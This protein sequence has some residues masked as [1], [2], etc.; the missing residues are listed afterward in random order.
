MWD[1]P[2]FSEIV[3]KRHYIEIAGRSVPID[4]IRFV[5]N[6]GAPGAKPILDIVFA[7]DEDEINS[8]PI[9]DA[10]FY[11]A[12]VRSLEQMRDAPYAGYAG[13]IGF[14]DATNSIRRNDPPNAPVALALP[15]EGF[16]RVVDRALLTPEK[17]CRFSEFYEPE[18]DV[19]YASTLAW[20][21]VAI[22]GAL[23]FAI[24]QYVWKAGLSWTGGA[25]IL[26]MIALA[27]GVHYVFRRIVFAVAGRNPKGRTLKMT[28][29][30]DTTVMIL[31]AHDDGLEGFVE[32]VRT[33]INTARRSIDETF[34]VDVDVLSRSIRI[35]SSDGVSTQR[36]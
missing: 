13:R 6:E 18:V 15:P 21:F 7:D 19:A 28:L 9:S 29:S 3:A 20:G 31:Q 34:T 16:L 5:L 26:I 23:L 27:A 35:S 33:A 4:Q 25:S 11:E 14:D 32:S 10:F 1:D 2:Q 17:A 12:A 24:P 30:N 36:F 22:F 8:V